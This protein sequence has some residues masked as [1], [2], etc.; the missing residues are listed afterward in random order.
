MKY[1][2]TL[3][4]AKDE[5]NGILAKFDF[6]NFNITDHNGFLAVPIFG[7]AKN[8]NQNPIKFAEQIADK[9]TD[10]DF[11]KTF[12]CEVKAKNG[13]LNF[14]YNEQKMVENVF[15]DFQ[16]LNDKYGQSNIG[17]SKTV[18]IDYSAPN[19]AK[20]FS[21]GHL[22]STIIGDSLCRI[23][24]LQGYRVIGDNHIGDWG[25]QFG[26]LITAYK[27]WGNET[28]IKLDPIKELLKLYVRFHQEAKENPQ[29]IDDARVWFKK[30]E[31]N[32]NKAKRY[33]KLMSDLSMVEFAK[34][35]KLLNINFDE[36]LGESFYIDK[37]EEICKLAQ[38][39][40]LA[41][42]APA[43][44]E[45][46]KESAT[47]KVLL[48]DLKKYGIKTPLLLKKSDGTTLYATRDLATAIYRINKYN[49]EK[50]LY[51][52]GSE[53]KLYFKQLF[54]VL[55]LLGYNP[56]KFAHIDFGL[57]GLSEG[58]MSTR[59]GRVIFL[60]D[61]INE[62]IKRVNNIINDRGMNKQLKQTTA[63]IVAVGAIKYA[64]LSN[65]RIHNIKFNWNKILNLKGNSGPYLQYQCVRIQ[66]ILEKSK[67]IT[68]SK[69]DTKLLKSSEEIALIESI[70][71]FNE[72]V[73]YSLVNNKPHNLANYLFSLATEFSKFYEKCPVLN[74]KSTELKNNRLYLCYMTHI[75]LKNG[76]NLLGIS[77]PCRM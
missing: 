31:Q 59:A 42:W 6:A 17:N 19:I 63:E 28:A 44:D 7:F 77:I 56:D 54:K 1:T 20:P 27:K 33:W 75:V 5:I 68:N 9:I 35:Y 46:G 34:I 2:Y 15:A 45:D 49:P 47:D 65:D 13:Y 10:K 24:K 18:V 21:I 66:S 51:V 67:F 69:V 23:Y 61:V 32:D 25:T 74:A 37:T 53:Q 30:L 22:R 16:K 14:Y 72:R 76:L 48:I 43:I 73:M 57:I 70:Y 58:K 60:N 38:E 40:G 62:A 55:E 3:D 4:K 71:K 29:L 52:V 41:K 11:Q 36:A 39:K 64:D 50:I 26:K 12:F 8:N